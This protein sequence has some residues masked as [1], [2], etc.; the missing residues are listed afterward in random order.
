[1]TYYGPLS[2]KIVKWRAV[3]LLYCPCFIIKHFKNISEI[4]DIFSWSIWSLS[5]GQNYK[6]YCYR[7]HSQDRCK[8]FF[9]KRFKL[10]PITDDDEPF[11]VQ[12]F[13]M[14][15]LEYR[16]NLSNVKVIVTNKTLLYVYHGLLYRRI[17]S[18]SSYQCELFYTSK[19]IS[20]HRICLIGCELNRRSRSI[21]HNTTV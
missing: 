17:I 19:D 16:N 13:T 20:S 4:L 15:I 5:W 12:R 21:N 7:F 10:C 1:M 3:F 14:L 8:T 6:L 2:D 18:L 9:I 11:D